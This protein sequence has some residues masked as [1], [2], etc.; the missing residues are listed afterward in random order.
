VRVYQKS[1]EEI[2]KLYRANQAVRKTLDEVYRG[3]P[4][5]SALVGQS[6]TSL[7]PPRVTRARFGSLSRARCG[8]M[9]AAVA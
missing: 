9:P 8:S 4:F 3:G 2:E 7:P 5:P 1:P 6:L